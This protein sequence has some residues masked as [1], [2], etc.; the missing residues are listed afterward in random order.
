MYYLLT[1]F[2]LRLYTTFPVFPAHGPPS[3]GSE[4][5]YFSSTLKNLYSFP[6]VQSACITI[7]PA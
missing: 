6:L 5:L 2:Y 1:C 4:D 7:W 3:T